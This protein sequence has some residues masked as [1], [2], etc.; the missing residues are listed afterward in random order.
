VQKKLTPMQKEVIHITR[1]L[2][3]IALGMGTKR[4]GNLGLKT[5]LKVRIGGLIRCFV[6][7]F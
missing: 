6:R 2:T 7:G 5:V 1:I 4:R 3:V